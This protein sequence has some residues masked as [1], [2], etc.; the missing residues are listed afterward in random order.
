LGVATRQADGHLEKMGSTA[1]RVTKGMAL[2]FA[3]AGAAAGRCLVVGLKKSVDAAK[4]AEASM[5][6]VKTIVD[7][8][9]IS[10]DK[11]AKQIDKVIQAHS[12]LT[13]FDDE[14]L[15]ES[16]ANMVRTTGNLSEA[17]KLNGLA[18]DIARAKGTD[19]AG[20]QSLLARVYNGSYTG[21]KRLG[22]AIEPV[23]KAQDALKAST[24]NATE[25]QIKAAKAAD[26][27]AT[28]QAAIAKL[29]KAFGGQAE[30]YGKTAAGAQ[31]RLSV[32]VENLQEKIGAKLAAGGR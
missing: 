17:F 27:A 11:H 21:V 16:F 28:S 26:K 20:A 5:A 8:A 7:N 24:K 18:A 2:G 12:R 13:G 9:G 30:A 25:E 23:T 29:Q 14:D 10:F 15:S 4:D 3:T 22:I 31:E 6:K 1:G 32:A 19:L